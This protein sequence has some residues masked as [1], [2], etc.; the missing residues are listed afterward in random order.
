MNSRVSGQWLYTVDIMN[1]YYASLIKPKTREA[2]NR[3]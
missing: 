2:G 3:R 1:I